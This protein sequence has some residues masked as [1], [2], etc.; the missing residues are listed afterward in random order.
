MSNTFGKIIKVHL[1]GASHDNVVGVVIEGIPAGINI[2]EDDFIEYINRRKGGSVGTTDRVEADNPKILT[3]II[4]EYTTGLPITIVFENKNKNS[5]PYQLYKS[6]HRPGHADFTQKSKY[7]KYADIRGGG[8]A[9]GRMTLPLM[10]AGVI[11][12]KCIP[13]V[14]AKAFIAHINGEKPDKID[15][16]KIRNEGDSLCGEIICI[17]ENIIA[18]IGEPFFDNIESYFSHLFFSIPGIKAVGFGDAWQTAFMRGS[19]YNDIFISNDGQ[20]TTNHCGGIQGGI[21]NGN[22]IVIHLIVR[23]PA[24]IK[25]EQISLNFDTDELE[26]RKITGSHD[27]AFILRLPPIIEAVSLLAIA[28]LY[29]YSK[30]YS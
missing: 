3:G 17:L 21:T 24:S 28:D 9:S 20:T 11:A 19:E 13:N 26:K 1:F 5:I 8:I 14:N 27:L 30:I 16:Q 25:K 18:G 23:P 22:A 12:S 10:I 29:L 6:W 7:G 2:I 15:W 4:D